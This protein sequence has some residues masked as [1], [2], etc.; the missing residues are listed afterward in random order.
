MIELVFFDAGETLLCPQPSFPELAASVIRGRG[1]DVGGADVIR[2]GRAVA[3]HFRLAADEGRTFS[4]SAD[5]SHAFWV[6]LY[7]EM[8]EHLAIADEGAP[9]EL[10]RVF[11][12][13][14]NYGLFPDTLPAL[15]ALRERGLRLGVISNFEGWLEALLDRLGV[16]ELFDVVAIS[17][18]LGWEKP[19]RRIFEWALERAR[20]EPASCAHVGDSPYFDAEAAIACG[21]RGILLDRH[22]RYGELEIDY[23]RI[24]TLGEV[25]PLVERMA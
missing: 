2:A 19:D 13:P 18:P 16:L 6:R 17:G 4:A 14:G 21:M 10:F 23:P 20:L 1:H 3:G 12:D 15:S 25:P 7:T 22:G 11:S 8:L 9:E 5:E 24:T